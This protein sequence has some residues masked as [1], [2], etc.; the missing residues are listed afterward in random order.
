M[1]RLAGLLASLLVP[2]CVAFA[3]TV[4][5]AQSPGQG[6]PMPIALDLAKVPVGSWADYT[7][8]LGQ[9]AKMKMRMALVGKSPAGTII[10]TTVDGEMLAALGGKM[11]MQVTLAPGA[12]K[13]GTAKKLVMQIG[14]GDPMEMPIEMTGGKQFTKPNPKTLLKSETITV[15][16]G[17]FKT[18]HYRD[19]SAKGEKV[20]FWI[21][22]DVPPFGL[23]KIEAEQKGNPQIKGP[24]TLELA[25]KGA[26]AKALVTKPAKPF[27][28]AAFIQQMQGAKAGG[29]PGGPPAG[30]PATA[31]AP[32]PA[33]KK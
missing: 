26:D 8:T 14:A 23:V 22:E 9:L 30:K 5:S 6:P 24:V 33:P 32:A 15:A 1:S 17:T 13:D 27:D 29:G 11:V 31:P 2:L 21:S 20:D 19:K 18:K 12:E 4:A 25:A 3:P 10:E 7:M 16:G 28:Q